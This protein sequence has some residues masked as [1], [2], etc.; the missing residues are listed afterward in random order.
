MSLFFKTMYIYH[1]MNINKCLIFINPNIYCDI[2][3]YAHLTLHPSTS[4]LRLGCCP[5]P[6]QSYVICSAWLTH[7]SPVMYLY[8]GNL[9]HHW[10]RYSLSYI[11]R[12][13]ITW[14]NADLFS[15]GPSEI[16]FSENWTKNTMIGIQENTF[17]NVIW[18]MLAILSLP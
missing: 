8:I 17:E 4:I 9:A 1:M 18:K 15:S 13:A 11:W 16:N 10:F 5:C 2:M 3:T 12:Q 7:R 6:N 14:T